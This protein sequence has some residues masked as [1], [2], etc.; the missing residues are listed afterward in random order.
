MKCYYLNVHFQG[1]RVKPTVIKTAVI[2][3]RRPMWSPYYSHVDY[4]RKEE[5]IMCNE[6]QILRFEIGIETDEEVVNGA[7]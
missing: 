1:Q 4:K 3:N 5:E 7:K 2:Q 6:S